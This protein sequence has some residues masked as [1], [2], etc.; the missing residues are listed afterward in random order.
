M[1][2]HHTV[3]VYYSY[4][5][6]VSV[7]S[8]EHKLADV[9]VSCSDFVLKRNHWSLGVADENLWVWWLLLL[10][11]MCLRPLTHALEIGTVIL[12]SDSGTSFSCQCTTSNII[13]RPKAVD[14]VRFV[15]PH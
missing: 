15:H 4:R 14:D 12:T 7:G 1:P 6:S 9:T 5:T 8:R 3:T 2:D 10:F 13:A 11:G